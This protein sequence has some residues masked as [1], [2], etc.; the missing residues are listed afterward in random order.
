MVLPSEASGGK[1]DAPE[2]TSNVKKANEDISKKETRE[3]RQYF[4]ATSHLNM[5]RFAPLRQRFYPIRQP[6]HYIRKVYAP[7]YGARED[8]DKPRISVHIEAEKKNYI[9]HIEEAGDETRDKRQ[10]F[11]MTSLMSP[12]HPIQSPLSSHGS[13]KE[14]AK[15]E[16]PKHRISRDIITEVPIRAEQHH[17]VVKTNLN[18][19]NEGEETKK[20]TIQRL[21]KRHIKESKKNNENEDE[22]AP[23]RKRQFVFNSE[24]PVVR[25]IV[26]GNKQPTSDHSPIGN[27]I[28]MI[29]GH[30]AKNILGLNSKSFDVFPGP[31]PDTK[32]NSVWNIKSVE[33]GTTEGG[34]ATQAY[35]QQN[36]GVAYQQAGLESVED[37]QR[38][39]DALKNAE[40]QAEAE[41][42]AYINEQ[43]AAVE[44]QTA[45]RIQQQKLE[46]E[47]AVERE[48]QIEN[49]QELEQARAGQMARLVTQRANERFL[50]MSHG[51][52]PIETPMR[53][54]GAMMM[55]M[56]QQQ[57][58]EMADADADASDDDEDAPV[59]RNHVVP[60]MLPTM[61]PIQPDYFHPTQVQIPMEAMAFQP[62]QR[63]QPMTTMAFQ[64]AQRLP[65]MPMI[66]PTPTAFI[67]TPSMMFMPT[68]D[69]MPFTEPPTPFFQE[70][71]SV[72]RSE[73]AQ[74]SDAAP[75]LQPY[76]TQKHHH[77][78]HLTVPT[79]SPFR[80]SNFP[81]PEMSD[82]DQK[83]EVH[84][85]IQTEKSKIPQ[86]QRVRKGEI[87][88]HS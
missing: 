13:K 12:A 1:E 41:K 85:H 70:L 37:S 30:S 8:P 74:T 79:E 2:L 4:P 23:I 49:E 77:R 6:S 16:V 7:F 35:T 87:S 78:K 57:Q 17:G 33:A 5:A 15:S 50:D 45:A 52:T 44:A 80:F 66:A 67:P 39:A 10:L 83:P 28:K 84:V 19:I 38:R 31:L 32:D 62:A 18:F 26:N 11:G 76:P 40:Q 82:D 20:S 9:T 24:P 54:V 29:A 64:P 43:T 86:S 75:Y 48:R 61:M 58:Q 65:P 72:H 22:H 63:L 71:E 21:Q 25:A 3:K 36:G 60:T 69:M 42:A 14:D 56:Q 27:L 51:L 73:Y 55:P 88:K 34:Q 53:S 59:Y 68:P 81:E 46:E 47:R